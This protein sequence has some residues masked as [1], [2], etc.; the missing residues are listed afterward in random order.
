MKRKTLFTSMA[1]CMLLSLFVFIFAS[2]D[3]YEFTWNFNTPRNI[4][5]SVHV[6]KG[7]VD[8]QP[9]RV[10]DHILTFE[11]PGDGTV[12][13]KYDNV[14]R[15]IFSANSGN[16][17]LVGTD[18]PP[19]ISFIILS[20]F[21]AAGISADI[22]DEWQ[23]RFPDDNHA[24]SVVDKIVLQ[25]EYRLNVGSIEDDTAYLNVETYTRTIENYALTSLIGD[26]TDNPILNW[27]IFLTGSSSYN[28]TDKAIQN[29]ELYYILMPADNYTA[30]SIT[31]SVHR[32]YV[33]V[34]RI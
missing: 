13:V 3:P 12:N 18:I 30:D 28:L 20:H 9:E 10:Q 1:L 21:P 31:N 6:E 29:A 22:G 25:D 27:N 32:Q 7:L 16:L 2:G 26:V 5:Y 33:I 19:Y 15:G 34:T 4:S 14:H 17:E 11:F 8:G 23:T 24:S